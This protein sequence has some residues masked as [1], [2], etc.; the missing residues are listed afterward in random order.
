MVRTLERLD[1]RIGLSVATSNRESYYFIVST[2][3]QKKE[4]L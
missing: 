3:V 2:K 4:V 1:L